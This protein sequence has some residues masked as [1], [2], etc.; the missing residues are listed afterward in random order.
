MEPLRVGDALGKGEFRAE[1]AI[2]GSF[3]RDTGR[4]VALLDE[5]ALHVNR[6]AGTLSFFGGLDDIVE[7]GAGLTLAAPA[8]SK[9][10]SGAAVGPTPE[11]TVGRAA[12]GF[13]ANLPVAEDAA[14]VSVLSE[15][16]VQ[17]G[18]THRWEC[19]GLVECQRAANLPP[20]TTRGSATVDG[21]LGVHG[22]YDAH[23]L[24]TP[25]VY[26]GAGVALANSAILVRNPSEQG[27]AES[28]DSG[29]FPDVIGLAGFGA[30]IKVGP[31]RFRLGMMMPFGAS[32]H[33]LGPSITASVGVIGGRTDDNAG[34]AAAE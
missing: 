6:F 19:D 2:E 13:R 33:G 34:P 12:L 24:V 10:T 32:E 29:I 22:D 21:F 15:V 1:A 20:T 25:Y 28:Q 4:E 16:G 26:I 3:P 11:G 7:A 30:D 23:P 27:A 17:W 31:G 8:W 9:A 5:S 18:R 14:H